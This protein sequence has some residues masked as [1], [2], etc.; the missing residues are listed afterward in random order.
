MKYYNVDMFV[1]HF[2]SVL[3]LEGFLN[4][5]VVISPQEKTP[6]SHFYNSQHVE[7][8]IDQ[9]SSLKCHL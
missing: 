5:A 4:S 2:I 8:G 3:V 7:N 1:F 9:W 6:T